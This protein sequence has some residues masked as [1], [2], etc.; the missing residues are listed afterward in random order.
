MIECYKAALSEAGWLI[1]PGDS[2]SPEAAEHAAL[3]I[4]WFARKGKVTLI[5]GDKGAR[6]IRGNAWSSTPLEVLLGKLILL[7][8]DVSEAS[9]TGVYRPGNLVPYEGSMTFE[10]RELRLVL[11][12]LTV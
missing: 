3:K 8:G 6:V 1:E 9:L 12:Q 11:A 7:P 2:V 10:E 5:M 4:L